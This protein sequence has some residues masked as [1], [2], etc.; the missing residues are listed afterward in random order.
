[1]SFG[2]LAALQVVLK[3]HDKS[4]HAFLRSFDLIIITHVPI[5]RL[6][7]CPIPILQLVQL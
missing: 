1:M 2:G 7:Q 5:K 6:N 3:H 4:R